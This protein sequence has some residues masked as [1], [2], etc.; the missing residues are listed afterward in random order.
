MNGLAD[1]CVALVKG[2]SQGNCGGC[3]WSL[4]VRVASRA[5]WLRQRDAK[6][7]PIE[8][9]SVLCLPGA[10]VLRLWPR[11]AMTPY[12]PEHLGS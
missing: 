4:P 3:G 9:L 2:F 5:F 6:A 11:G 7:M 12:Q 8:D 10:R 1:G